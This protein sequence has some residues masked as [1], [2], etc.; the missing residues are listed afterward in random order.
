MFMNLLRS[1]VFEL[2][3]N[4]YPHSEDLKIAVTY[5]VFF[6]FLKKRLVGVPAVVQWDQWHLCGARTQVRSLP[7]AVV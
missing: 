7:G 5:K 2:H 3:V 6:F 1:L 4:S